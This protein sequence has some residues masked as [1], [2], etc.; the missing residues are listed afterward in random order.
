MNP[1]SLAE[2]KG[3]RS[4]TTAADASTAAERSEAR[5][6]ARSFERAALS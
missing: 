2:S 4:S 1:R 5:S 3:E 6:A